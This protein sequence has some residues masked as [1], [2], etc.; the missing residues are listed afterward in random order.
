[1]EMYLW[2]HLWYGG[3]SRSL[4]FP[5]KCICDHSCDMVELPDH[6][7]FHGN[8]SV[9]IAVIW[10]N[11]Q[12][13]IVSMEMYLWLQLWY[14]GTSRSLLFPWKCIC[15]YICD[16]LELPD[17]YCF[18]G[19]V[20]VIT[21][22][23]WW[24]FQIII[25]SMEM[26]LWLQLWYGGTSRSL[27]FPWKFICDYICDMVELPDHYCFHG[28]VSVI[29]AVI[30]WNFQIIIVSMEIYLWL[31]LW[32]GGT[33]RSLLF[34]WKFICDYSCDMVELPDHYCF[35][36]NVSVIT[37]VIWWNFQIII[38]SMEMYLWLHLWYGGT[39]GSLMRT[40]PR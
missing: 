8:V 37:S 11:F 18:H 25:V 2:L 29:T 20:S 32:Y 5:W 30:W 35:H 13:I 12:I 10:W 17:H 19:N 39:S 16:M 40:T 4:L 15:D 26:Y 27:L 36:G 22:V 21:A 7:C 6:Y 24:N 14:G 23:I 31:H 3:T 33:S 1:M 9:I 34:S 38:V 28:N